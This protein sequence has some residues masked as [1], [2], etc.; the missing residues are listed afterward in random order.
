MLQVG[1]FFYTQHYF[2]WGM[3]QNF[4]LAAA[5]GA[6][7]VAGSLTSASIAGRYG[8]RRGLV[9]V[10]V[11][12]STIALCAALTRAAPALL[13]AALLSHTFISALNWPAVESLVTAGAD[14]HTMSRRV[15]I[16]NLVWSATNAV[17]FAACGTIIEHWQAGLFLVPALAH[18]S[19]ALL[20]LVYSRVELPES[21][22]THGIAHGHVEPEPQLLARRTLAMWLA[23]ISLPATYVVV[24]SLMAM[25]PSLPVI[26]PLT[27]AVATM[28]GSAWMAARFAM[29]VWLGA[30]TWWHTRPMLLLGSAAAMLFAFIGVTIA[31][32]GGMI[33]SQ[34]ILGAVMGIIYSGSLYFGMVLSQG[35]TEHG[36]YHEA[37][38]GLGS[39]LGPG[40]AALT[41]QYWPGSVR[42]GVTAVACVIATTVLAAALAAAR[43][44]KHRP[45]E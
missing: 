18:A 6:V 12:M 44:S 33:V 1:I 19:S 9:A 27:P 20:M 38:I 14:A 25:M 35:S 39:V 15:G 26:K 32:L 43:A 17:V 36:G 21:A 30:A 7:Y 31:P 40:V 22:I 8:R 45:T 23:R 16:Y 37:L 24:Y 2:G 3:K 34:L 42:A 4:M 10:Y 28:V 11:G 13:I 29:F 5:Q 41:Q